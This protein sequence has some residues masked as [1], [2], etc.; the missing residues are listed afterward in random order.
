MTAND[1][2]CGCGHELRLHDAF[3]C[4]AF[5]GAFPATRGDQHYCGCREVVR[6]EQVLVIAAD[7]ELKIR[8]TGRP[9]ANS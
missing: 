3:G 4:A 8:V 1:G 9:L 2:V 5:L 7:G 6:E